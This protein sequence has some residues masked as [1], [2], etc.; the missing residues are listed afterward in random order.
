MSFIINNGD[1]DPGMLLGAF[2]L[3]DTPDHYLVTNDKKVVYSTTQDGY[4]EGIKWLHTLQEEGLIDSEAFTQKWDTLLQK[5][6]IT[7]MECSLHGIEQML[8]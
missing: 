5:E 1:Q 6:K 3:G 4:K 7:V 2:G 8:L